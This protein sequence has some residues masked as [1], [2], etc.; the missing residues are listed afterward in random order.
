MLFNRGESNVMGVYTMRC[1]VNLL[2]PGIVL[3]AFVPALAQGPTYHVGKNASPEE[4]RPLDISIGPEGKELPPGS[5]TAKDGP[6]IYAQKCAFCHGATG[7]EGPGPHL[8]GPNT[9]VDVIP[10]P[11]TLWDYINRDMPRDNEGSLSANE[12]YALTALLLHWRGLIEET[13]VLDAKTLPK[14]RMPNRNGFY[15][16]RPEWNRLPRLPYGA[17]PYHKEDK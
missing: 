12:V 4:I 10:V 17:W 5:G 16:P 8:S 14:I 7:K 15:P 6:K 2:V 9:V 13:T 3:I 11:T 1:L